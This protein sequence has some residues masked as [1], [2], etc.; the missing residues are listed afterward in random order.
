M[1]QK[2]KTEKKEKNSRDDARFMSGQ[3]KWPHFM[4]SCTTKCKEYMGLLYL[5]T[6]VT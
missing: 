2:K 3:A 5:L 1:D 6:S 4:V